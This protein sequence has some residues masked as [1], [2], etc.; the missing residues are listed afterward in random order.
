MSQVL[1][2]LV[3]ESK[4]RQ[5]EVL[6][7]SGWG[8]PFRIFQP[9]NLCFWVLMLGYIG[10]V[11]TMVHY[12]RPEAGA[13]SV[14]IGFGTGLFAIYAVPWWLYLSHLNRYTTVPHK[15]VLIGF[16]WG[17]I[18]ATFWIAIRVNGAVLTIYTKAFG[19]VWASAWAPALTAP[20][21]E[22]TAKMLGLILILGLVPQVIRTPFDG[23]I[24]G[25]FIGL[26]FQISEDILY[27]FQGASAQFGSNQ[28]SLVVQM[29]ALRGAAG[30]FSHT[31]FSAIY[32]AGLMWLL[33]RDGSNHRLRGVGL[34]ILATLFHMTWD[35]GGVYF[36]HL[37]GGVGPVILN[38][39]LTIVASL[40]TIRLLLRAVNRDERSW[41]RAVL[42]PEVENGVLT[43]D[44][45]SVLSGGRKQRRKLLHTVHGHHTKQIAKHTVAAA[46][47]LA[48]EI[49]NG[50]G[51]DTDRVLH[52]R[53]EVA[54]IRAG[55]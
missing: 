48:N 12:I 54:R 25:A 1:E 55:G 29:L 53:Q 41:V 46:E 21:T 16:V 51:Q 19:Q 2:P 36:N 11:T 42:Q 15:V 38:Y 5:L 10:G 8:V 28:G 9:R 50:G 47:D 49:A 43:A 52:A 39:A 32:C 37:L 44:E 3:S 13:Y 45:V 4:R 40:I 24:V 30:L 27:A 18:A 35:S 7:H 23:F 22:E 20:F 14:A 6:H 34:M 17:F 26:G 33:N 31:M